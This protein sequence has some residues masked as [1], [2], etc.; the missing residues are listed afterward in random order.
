MRD[1]LVELPTPRAQL[2]A[3][4]SV[5]STLLGSSILAL[6][7]R[8][9]FERWKSLIDPDARD[10]ILFT[11]AGVWMPVAVAQAHYDACDRLHL[12]QDEIIG[13]GNA[14]ARLTQQTVLSLALRLATQTG[15]T[16]WMA[17]AYSPRLWSRLYQ[18]S[19]VEIAKVG[20]KDAEFLTIGNPLGKFAYWRTGLRGILMSVVSP[21]ATKVY[22]REMR[23]PDAGDHPVP[24]RISWV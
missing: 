15:T 2:P 20:P 17:L 11:P 22:V 13:M 7:E 3:C 19:G 5:R 8:G 12:P 21:F 6:K 14:V 23:P 9:H 24:Y 1:M 16:P 4:T 18:G 10:P